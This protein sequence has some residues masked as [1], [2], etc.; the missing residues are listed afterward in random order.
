[1]RRFE[2]V[3]RRYDSVQE[4]VYKQEINRIDPLAQKQTRKWIEKKFLLNE[5]KTEVLRVSFARPERQF[6]PKTRT[7]LSYW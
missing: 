1:M 5:V 3:Y 7:R 4:P 6:K 2:T